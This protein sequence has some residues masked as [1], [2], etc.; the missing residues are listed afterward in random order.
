MQDNAFHYRFT[1]LILAV[2][3]KKKRKKKKKNRVEC[4]IGFLLCWYRGQFTC[5]M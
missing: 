5:K 2:L 3:K 1:T 4:D